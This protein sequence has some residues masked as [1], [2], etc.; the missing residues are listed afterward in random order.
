MKKTFGEKNINLKNRGSL[1]KLTTDELLWYASL[2]RK[3]FS[4]KQCLIEYI[5]K[6]NE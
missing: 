3:N 6:I 4:F 5:L 2:R 1:S